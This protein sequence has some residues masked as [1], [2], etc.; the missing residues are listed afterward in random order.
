MTGGQ[1]PAIAVAV[2]S[3]AGPRGAAALRDGGYDGPLAR[4]LR[5][6]APTA[7][8]RPTGGGAPARFTGGPSPTRDTVIK[9]RHAHPTPAA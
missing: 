6:L 5:G 8:K 7:P 3:L 4:L 1:R 9:R 2:A